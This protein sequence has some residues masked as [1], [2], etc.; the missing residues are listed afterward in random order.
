MTFHKSSI[1]L[2][3]ST[4]L[5]RIYESQLNVDWESETSTSDTRN[6]KK[7]SR[8]KKGLDQEK[9]SEVYISLYCFPLALPNSR[10]RHRTY[11]FDGGGKIGEEMFKRN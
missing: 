3:F 6:N 11:V 2:P 7:L 5:L 8:I 10:S 1:R 4:I 9:N